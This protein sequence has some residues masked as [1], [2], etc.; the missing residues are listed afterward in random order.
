MRHNNWQ[1]YYQ[2]KCFG[3]HLEKISRFVVAIERT[4]QI[5]EV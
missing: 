1:F 2:L 3:T 4:K 5:S